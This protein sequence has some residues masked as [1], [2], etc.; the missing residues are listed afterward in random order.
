MV[1]KEFYENFK[2]QF[3]LSPPTTYLENRS[4]YPEMGVRSSQP[5]PAKPAIQELARF[6]QAVRFINVSL[7]AVYTFDWIASLGDEIEL[8]CE[9]LSYYSRSPGH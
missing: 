2:V 4:P 1:A 6:T 7:L 5:L 8:I 9:L 3:A